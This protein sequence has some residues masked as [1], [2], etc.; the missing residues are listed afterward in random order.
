MHR[1]EHDV[2][3]NGEILVVAPV[4]NNEV[5]IEDKHGN[6]I[7]L[8]YF[9]NWQNVLHGKEFVSKFT[10]IDGTIEKLRGAM[11]LSR[12]V[13]NPLQATFNVGN[14]RHDANIESLYNLLM[15]FASIGTKEL[16]ILYNDD[17]NVLFE[18]E[19][20]VRAVLLT[21]FPYCKNNHLL[22]KLTFD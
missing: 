13:K 8:S 20:G 1:P 3:T 18:N 10:N 12:Y 4:V 5:F 19:K 11:K 21:F 2:I 15:F 16:K 9:P 17:E 14:Y 6:K 7:E 22:V